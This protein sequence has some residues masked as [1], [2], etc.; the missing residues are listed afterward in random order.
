[1]AQQEPELVRRW[2][3]RQASVRDSCDGDAKVPK[4]LEISQPQEFRKFG[5]HKVLHTRRKPRDC[6]GETEYVKPPPPVVYVGLLVGK[7][8]GDI[9][10]GPLRPFL[11]KISCAL[12]RRHSRSPGVK[13][14][15]SRPSS[16]RTRRGSNRDRST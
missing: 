8:A 11:F 7:L 15:P 1:M 13:S 10:Q 5:F 14:S 2:S 4:M 12:R 3:V 6:R 9:R 16:A